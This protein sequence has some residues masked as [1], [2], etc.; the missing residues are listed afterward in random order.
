[1]VYNIVVGCLLLSLCL[2]FVAYFKYVK[3]KQHFFLLEVA[4]VYALYAKNDK[5]KRLDVALIMTILNLFRIPFERHYLEEIYMYLDR[6]NS[7]VIQ[8]RTIENLNPAIFDTEPH[9]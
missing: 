5:D 1:M 7:D 4:C 6:L 9:Q 8:L 2:L 3:M